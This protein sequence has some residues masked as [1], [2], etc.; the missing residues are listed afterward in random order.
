MPDDEIDFRFVPDPQ[1]REFPH[2]GHPGPGGTRR[3]PLSILRLRLLRRNATERDRGPQRRGRVF[4]ERE[5]ERGEL[6]LTESHPELTT[7]WTD[8]ANPYDKRG[9]AG[10]EHP[11]CGA[12]HL[13]RMHSSSPAS[14]FV[15]ENEKERN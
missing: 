2:R 12:R 11:A 3:P 1:A 6:I 14:R 8:E 10:G 5:A 15:T 4:P 7:G 13:R 9:L